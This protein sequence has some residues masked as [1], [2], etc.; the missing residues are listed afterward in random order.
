M[1]SVFVVSQSAG[2]RWPNNSFLIFRSNSHRS[3]NGSAST[4]RSSSCVAVLTT[5]TKE[6]TRAKSPFNATS[7][8]E[9]SVTKATSNNTC[10]STA[11]WNPIFAR[12]V[13]AGSLA[14]TG[15]GITSARINTSCTCTR[16]FNGR[17]RRACQEKIALMLVPFHLVDS[18]SPQPAIKIKKN[19][20]LIPCLL[21]PSIRFKCFLMVNEMFKFLKLTFHS[22]A[23]NPPFFSGKMSEYM[24]NFV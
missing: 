20:K 2:L 13:D 21:R 3:E 18:T 24:A 16:K 19:S 10:I 4:V 15:Y 1:T 8:V 22:Q 14:R 17:L 6:R 9:V 5:T 7:A 12:S 23:L 11:T